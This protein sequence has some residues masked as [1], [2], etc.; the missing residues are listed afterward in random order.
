MATALPE[1]A[2]SEACDRD[3]YENDGEKHAFAVAGVVAG[4][5]RDE[6]R[7]RESDEGGL[8]SDCSSAVRD[9]AAEQQSPDEGQYSDHG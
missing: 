4:R 7:G 5:C 8:G 9:E 1:C 6:D 2:E 3:R